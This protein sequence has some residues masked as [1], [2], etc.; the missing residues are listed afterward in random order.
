[1]SLAWC[2]IAL[3]L[4][5][6]DNPTS[7]QRPTTWSAFSVDNVPDEIWP[8]TIREA[9]RI[10][11]QNSRSLRV[12]YS[13]VSTRPVG[14]NL[15]APIIE[16]E[17]NQPRPACARKSSIVVEPM[18]ADANIG[19][20]KSE[21]IA[22]V[23]L[24]DNLYWNL[25]DAHAADWA[26]DKAVTRAKDLV[27][28]LEAAGN[29]D[30]EKDLH[31]LADGIR[32]LKQFEKDLAERTSEVLT[33]ERVFRKAL[34]VPEADGRRAIPVTPPDQA[35][36]VF[37]RER[38][39]VLMTKAPDLLERK[40]FCRLPRENKIEAIQAFDDSSPHPEADHVE[41]PTVVSTHLAAYRVEH[42]ILA[43]THVDG[44]RVGLGCGG[45]WYA[46]FPVMPSPLF[47]QQVVHHTTRPLAD[48][49]VE[50][51]THY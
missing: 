28:V 18:N 42:L 46:E 51:D 6:E 14:C 7:A 8:L 44:H 23:R 10:A 39:E 26:A 9:N 1:M 30:C 31:D 2:V 36:V 22:L 16:E 37:T 5:G 29:P 38:L 4:T 40:P 11:F 45:Y 21:A 24:V 13:Y 15:G 3:A 33:A 47:P 12:T 20:T 19:Q 41:H 34:G 50:A 48:A 49:V 27:E 32:R 17:D 35:P 43:Y 25:A